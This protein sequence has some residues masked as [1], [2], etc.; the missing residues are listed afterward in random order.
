MPII[1]IRDYFFFSSSFDIFLAVV[2][3]H[4]S[5]LCQ[6]VMVTTKHVFSAGRSC[7]RMIFI[8]SQHLLLIL[9]LIHFLLISFFGWLFMCYSIA[10]IRISPLRT[11]DLFWL[12]RFLYSKF[13][14]NCTSLL[15]HTHTHGIQIDSNRQ[16]LQCQWPWWDKY[17]N[18]IFKWK[19]NTFGNGKKHRIRIRFFKS[20]V[21]RANFN[22]FVQPCAYFAFFLNSIMRVYMVFSSAS[23]KKWV[24]YC[25]KWMLCSK[26][27][28]KF[29]FLSYWLESMH[30]GKKA[31]HW[32]YL[33]TGY[34]AFLNSFRK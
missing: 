31:L 8:Q 32:M 11:D 13:I 7:V 17:F 34:T 6:C 2:S 27:N 9:L 18:S 22:G 12:D 23:H 15:T 5:S 33:F 28:T 30:W 20:L 25:E 26:C 3:T 14:L 19:Q 4:S 16:R 21:E 1:R 10:Y 24:K 29:C